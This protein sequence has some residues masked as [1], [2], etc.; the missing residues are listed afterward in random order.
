MGRV[1]FKN[2][3]VV[4][5]NDRRDVIAGGSVVVEDGRIVFV[6]ENPPA[7]GNVSVVEEIDASGCIVM[8]GLSTR[9]ST[10]GIR[11]SRE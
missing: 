7:V 11:C 2:G 10:T 9:T 4:T 3:L 5:V 1:L 6:G 8:P